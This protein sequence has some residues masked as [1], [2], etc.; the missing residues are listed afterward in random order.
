MW[1]CFPCECRGEAKNNQ[2]M[3][4]VGFFSASAGV[5]RRRRW[6]IALDL[7]FPARAGVSRGR[8]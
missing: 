5:D 6:R 4:M 8:I 1:M 7:V 2:Q 3:M